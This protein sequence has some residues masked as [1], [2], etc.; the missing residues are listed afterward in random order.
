MAHTLGIS[1]ARHTVS[2]IGLFCKREHPLETQMAHTLGISHARHIDR[3]KPLTRDTGETYHLFDPTHRSHPISVSLETQKPPTRNTDLG[4][5]IERN[6]HRLETQI[7]GEEDRLN[8]RSLLQNI[9]SF[10]G[11]FCKRE[12]PLE[13]QIAH[14]LGKS[15]ARHVDRKKPPPKP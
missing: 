7:W 3:K 10:I 13:T 11:L 5:V 9:V 4:T 14:T 8:H 15:P 1:P 6:P 2:F 12:H